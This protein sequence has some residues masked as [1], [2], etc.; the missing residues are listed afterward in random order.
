MVKFENNFE[1]IVTAPGGQSDGCH[2]TRITDPAYKKE[3]KERVHPTASANELTISRT[4]KEA[5][6]DPEYGYEWRQ[7][8]KLELGSLLAFDT[9]R[10]EDLSKGQN[11]VGSRWVFD[12]TRNQEGS[13]RKFKARLVAQGFAQKR[14]FDYQE[15]FTPTVKYDSLRLLLVLAATEDL[16]IFIKSMSRALTLLE[17]LR[18]HLYETSRGH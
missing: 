15:T 3:E 2:G 16:E 12:L 6:E 10:M 17:N 11:P 9:W 1:Y 14:G 18:G 5:I 7:A 8:I 4:Y 13:I